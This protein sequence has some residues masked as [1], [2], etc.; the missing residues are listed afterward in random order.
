MRPRTSPRAILLSSRSVAFCARAAEPTK[1]QATASAIMIGFIY[2]LL[3]VGPVNVERTNW[4]RRAY[5]Q[6]GIGDD[7]LPSRQS[8]RSLY[9]CLLQRNRESQ[10][11]AYLVH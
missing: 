5:H 6:F 1:V 4:V 11:R 8:A 10:A 7:T 9:G 3:F 2:R